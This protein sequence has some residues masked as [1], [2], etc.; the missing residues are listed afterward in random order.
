MDHVEYYP[1]LECTAPS[2]GQALPTVTAGQ[3]NVMHFGHEE[4]TIGR[5]WIAQ[6]DDCSLLDCTTPLQGQALHAVNVGQSNVQHSGRARRGISNAVLDEVAQLSPVFRT[7]TPQ[8]PT[9]TA[10]HTVDSLAGRI[11]LSIMGR[12]GPKRW[13][14]H[15]SCKHRWRI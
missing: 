12:S 14:I 5:S 8:R 13:L 6:E 3:S 1:L 2:E 4:E 11:G 10:R 9:Q 15:P 7:G